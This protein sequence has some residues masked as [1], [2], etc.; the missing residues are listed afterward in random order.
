MAVCHADAADDCTDDADESLVSPTQKYI[1]KVSRSVKLFIGCSIDGTVVV[2]GK[3]PNRFRREY[4]G[5]Y[6][7]T[8]K[9]RHE[10]NCRINSLVILGYFGGLVFLIGQVT[11]MIMVRQCGEMFVCGRYLYISA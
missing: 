2:P 1:G 5:V 4:I 8:S 11:P 3:T 7:V 9:V 6:H 10:S